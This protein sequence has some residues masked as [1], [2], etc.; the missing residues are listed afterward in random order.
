VILEKKSSK[1][2]EKYFKDLN[3]SILVINIS[4][5]WGALEENFFE[6]LKSFYRL[7]V[8]TTVITHKNSLSY[9]KLSDQDLFGDFFIKNTKIVDNN[10]KFKK[11][12]LF[13]MLK[14]LLREKNYNAVLL[15]GIDWSFSP[16]TL[17][18]MFNR[19]IT[20][21]AF[22]G[23]TLE[24]NHNLHKIKF[25]ANRLDSF[26]VVNSSLI[27]QY[28]MS[29][30]IKTSKIRG[31]ESPFRG[32]VK[33]SLAISK[34]RYSLNLNSMENAEGIFTFAMN[35]EIY[36]SLVQDI[37]KLLFLL[38]S[39]TRIWSDHARG[40]PV[41]KKIKSFQLLF[42]E[43]DAKFQGQL[44]NEFQSRIN[45]SSLNFDI[46][47]LRINNLSELPWDSINLWLLNPSSYA[48]CQIDF[49]AL[50]N[51]IAVLVPRVKSN[52]QFLDTKSL[53]ENSFN[54][55]DSR[56][57]YAKLKIILSNYKVE[58]ERTYL[59]AQK[60]LDKLEGAGSRSINLSSVQVKILETHLA[61]TRFFKKLKFFKKN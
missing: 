11:F 50:K 52:A 12:T 58:R 38:N 4:D 30:N 9:E 15:Y 7:K 40:L 27:Q 26:F 49:Y 57:F 37:D 55:N 48:P 61:R 51:A 41:F 8:N 13:K 3:L 2:T 43:R 16:V 36:E 21:I 39:F 32:H 19:F 54:L 1:F 22:S 42:I 46:K 20:F 17:S 24:Y 6:D 45:N 10:H 35:L 60:M 53:S 23:K 5:N 25:L 14:M 47:I 28:K 33:T 56:E 31:L 29:L 59:M 18:L 34:L 44:Y